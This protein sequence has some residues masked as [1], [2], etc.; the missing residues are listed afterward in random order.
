MNKSRIESKRHFRV[1]IGTEEHGL[2]ISSTP[3]SA[4]RK[5]VT[6]LCASNKNKKVEFYIREIT[7]GSKKKDLWGLYR[8]FRKIKKSN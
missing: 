2:Y 3:S 8:I 7:Q 1:I 4:A 6:K 5:A